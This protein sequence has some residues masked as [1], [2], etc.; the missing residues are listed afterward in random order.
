M[1]QVAEILQ[2]DFSTIYKDPPPDDRAQ[3]PILSTRTI[4]GL[5]NQA[6]DAIAR[7]HGRAQ[8]MARSIPQ[9]VRQLV[10]TVKR[11][12]RPE[13]GDDW[14]EHFTSIASTGSWATS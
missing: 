5:G 6:D 13:W 2:K 11:Y 8:R 9:T 10:F 7:V 1:D 12:Y 3:R 4:A 14:R